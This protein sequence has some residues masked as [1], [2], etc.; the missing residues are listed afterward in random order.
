MWCRTVA[1]GVPERS[2]ECRAAVFRLLRSKAQPQVDVADS[3]GVDHTTVFRVEARRTALGVN[4][5]GR[6]HRRRGWGRRGRRHG[7]RHVGCVVGIVTVVL[8]VSGAYD[9]GDDKCRN[10]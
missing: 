10:G 4:T 9:A 2:L 6:F 3:V 7:W 1:V 5:K 8:S